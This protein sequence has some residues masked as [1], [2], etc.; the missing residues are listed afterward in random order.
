[1]QTGGAQILGAAGGPLLSS[2]LVSDANVRGVLAQGAIALGLGLA[3]IAAVRFAVRHD[4][5]AG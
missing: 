1:M 3:M 4:K 5:A 2:F